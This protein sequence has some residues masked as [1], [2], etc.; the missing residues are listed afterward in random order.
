MYSHTEYLLSKITK[1]SIFTFLNITL[2]PLIVTYI[3]NT[4]FYS[5]DG[6]NGVVLTYHLT[7]II[8]E[9]VGFISPKV[10]I[11]KMGLGIPSIRKIIIKK[12]YGILSD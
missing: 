11:F 12:K 7:W 1:I 8:T 2:V 6:I 5:T 3:G 10:L 4:K 9:T